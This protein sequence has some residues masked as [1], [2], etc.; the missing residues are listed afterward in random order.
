MRAE[1]SAAPEVSGPRWAASPTRQP[2]SGLEPYVEAVRGHVVLVAAILVAVVVAS[3]AWLAVRAPEYRANAEIFVTPLPAET[4]ALVGLPLIQDLRE[5]TR[6]IQTAAALVES[7]A[8]AARTA[9]TLG[10]TWTRKQVERAITVEPKGETNILEVS[11][12][13]DSP[14]LAANLA[15]TYSSSALAVRRTTLQQLARATIPSVRA[16]LR[17]LNPANPGASELQSALNRLE[18]L[19]AGRDPTLSLAQAATPPT[20]ALGAPG[21]LIVALALLAGGVLGVATAVAI[22]RITP[23]RITSED[24]LVEVFPLPIL[25][26]I[27]ILPRQQRGVLSLD[28][29]PEAREALR[30]VQV[31]LD[32]QGERPR[33]V[34]ITSPSPEDGKTTTALA[35]GVAIADAGARVILIDTDVRRL[36]IRTG[37][38]ADRDA[39]S[40]IQART[41]RLDQG[42]EPRPSLRP[43]LRRVA[44]HPNL[45]LLDAMDVGF[46][47]ADPHSRSRFADLVR[48]A[49]SEADYV[50]LDTP[51][52]GVISDALTLLEL[53]D[54]VLVVAR[55]RATKRLHVEVARD[56][57]GRA[58]VVPA[59]YLV[60]GER[61]LGSYPY[62]VAPRAR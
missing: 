61:T 41:R 57:L 34:M 58:G 59:G 36:P 30:S 55:I 12:V 54:D 60:I 26:R 20:S 18:S 15:N 14:Q 31:Q 49:G 45:Q 23:R 5:P 37:L 11:A 50:L 17:Q 1:R 48:A 46:D 27:P 56:L 53:V 25:A 35:F 51:P 3:I 22:D 16:R 2:Q 10:P 44:G 33:T 9:E 28:V 52:V 7:H 6:T 19:A 62:P 13:A 43:L 38:E 47:S 8:A 24:E 40:T 29:H 42:G 21:W 39:V 4:V 32:L